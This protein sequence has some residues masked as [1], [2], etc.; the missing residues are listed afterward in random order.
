MENSTLE[1]LYSEYRKPNCSNLSWFASFHIDCITYSMLCCTARR[2]SPFVWAIV[3]Y[4]LI[5]SNLIYINSI[6]CK[7]YSTPFVSAGLRD[8]KISLATFFLLA[9]CSFTLLSILLTL[10]NRILFEHK[11]TAFLQ[12]PQSAIFRSF[13]P[14]FLYFL[15]F[16]TL[17]IF[18]TTINIMSNLCR[19]IL[20]PFSIFLNIN[21]FSQYRNKAI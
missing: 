10:V 17:L 21:L 11:A 16:L 9:C 19:E 8:C 1:G 5:F 13:S 15:S 18:Y 7:I 4:N 20:Y 12:N 3:S 2:A 14:S 6:A